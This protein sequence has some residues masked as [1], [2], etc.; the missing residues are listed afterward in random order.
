[1]TPS[2]AEPL[3]MVL[4]REIHR[5]VDTSARMKGASLYRNRRASVRYHRSCPIFVARLADSLVED[6]RATLHDIS[7]RGIGFYCDCR[8]PVDAILGIKLFWTDLDAPRV[9]VC[10]RHQNATADGILIGAQFITDDAKVCR[11]LEC[12]PTAWYG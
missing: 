12:C 4:A 8:F 1:M 9:P 7:T 6:V 3:S 11:L 10:V 2:A 5:F